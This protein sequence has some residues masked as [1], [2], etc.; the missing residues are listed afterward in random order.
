MIKLITMEQND[1]FNKEVQLS[2]TLGELLVISKCFDVVVEDIL[3]KGL[4][5]DEP[6]NLVFNLGAI[7]GSLGL[8]NIVMTTQDMLNNVKKLNEMLD[9]QIND[10]GI[11]V[12]MKNPEEDLYLKYTNNE[13]VPY[14]RISKEEVIERFNNQIAG[15]N[16][17][18]EK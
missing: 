10:L 3:E 15:F 5:K 8:N 6:E 7:A 13:I 4:R 16:N 17:E 11:N 9:S 1:V 14:H 12:V 18:I 2:V